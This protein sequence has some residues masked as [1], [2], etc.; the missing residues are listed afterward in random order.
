MWKR[1]PSFIFYLFFFLPSFFCYFMNVLPLC[2]S[3]HH[4]CAWYPQRS[5]EGTSS[6]G[7][8][9]IIGCETPWR[10]W[11]LSGFFHKSSRYY[12]LLRELS[13]PILLFYFV[14]L[15]FHFGNFSL[16][17][18]CP[19]KLQC[20]AIIINF[21]V[22]SPPGNFSFC[23]MEERAKDVLFF[24]CPDQLLKH[25]CI[26]SL[27]HLSVSSIMYIKQMNSS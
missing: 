22:Q 6:P 9:V 1:N 20:P 11:E 27:F 10:C 21:N 24:W 17:Y 16:I 2:V 7:T 5:K 8:G 19:T 15:L 25:V 14:F 4:I 3:V 13:S 12:L 26:R 18:P 23:V